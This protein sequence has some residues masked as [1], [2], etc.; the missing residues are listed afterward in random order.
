MKKVLFLVAV[1]TLF[2]SCQKE[3][4]PTAPATRFSLKAAIESLNTK[5]ALNSSHNLVWSEG[6]MIGVYVDE[7]SW[8][9]KNQPFILES[10][11]G[12]T[13]G[14]FEWAEAETGT[15]SNNAVAAYFP[16]EGGPLNPG[17]H[18]NYVG[19]YP[20]QYQNNVYDDG[21]GPIMYFKLPQA[22]YGY[23]NGEMR[24]PLI[25]KLE[26]DSAA[27]S[28]KPI[29]F[30]YAGAAVKLTI[31]NLQAGTK[32]A[33][34]IADNQQIYGDYHIDPSKAGKDAM[35]VDGDPHPACNRIWLDLTN[36]SS[37]EDEF[38][39]IFPVPTLDSPVFTFKLYDS[40]Y[41]CVW[42]KKTPKAQESLGRGDILVMPALNFPL[43]TTIKVGII[44]YLLGEMVD[45]IVHCW[46]NEG[47]M[48]I[49]LTPTSTT[50]QKAL[51][52]SYWDNEE[53]TFSIFTA[54]IPY[55]YYG[56]KICAR[57]PGERWFG[58]DGSLENPNAYIFNYDGDRALYE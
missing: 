28:Y 32:R 45:F 58:E 24:T 49:H 8:T 19:G 46:G 23:K 39:F 15:F 2:F 44:N 34:I 17:M 54:E 30:K 7:P 37:G 40:D 10:G 21:S 3:N 42:S 20:N 35:A 16:W 22:H 47:N 12:S 14:K 11:A 9:Y 18:G 50:V 1:A 25:A 52:D 53:Q 27:Q 51:G 38:V 4:E 5:A 33:A 57:G 55:G 43:P 36:A 56:Y 29:D 31:Q 41:N 13:S 48:D 26:Y 6:D